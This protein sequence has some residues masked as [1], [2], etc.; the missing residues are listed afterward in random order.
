M[1]GWILTAL[2]IV[3][4]LTPYALGVGMMLGVY[5][6]NITG[7]VWLPFEWLF[8]TG[9]YRVGWPFYIHAAIFLCA[10]IGVWAS[11]GTRGF[12]RSS[13]RVALFWIWGY[14]LIG[15]AGIFAIQ[16]ANAHLRPPTWWLTQ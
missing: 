2:L 9:F 6:Y 13:G 14:V 1:L 12:F 15:W 7:F 8:G 16:G 5:T 11:Y 3:V 10:L 4:T